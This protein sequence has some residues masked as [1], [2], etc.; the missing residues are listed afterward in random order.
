MLGERWSGKCKRWSETWE[1][2]NSKNILEWPQYIVNCSV[3]HRVE[4]MG[5][6]EGEKNKE[7]QDRSNLPMILFTTVHVLWLVVLSVYCLTSVSVQQRCDFQDLPDLSTKANVLS[8]VRALFHRA[9]VEVGPTFYCYWTILIT[10]CTCV[11]ICSSCNA[12]HQCYQLQRTRSI[13]RLN[14]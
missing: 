4:K 1:G 14:N 3:F 13:F 7:K 8:M 10:A 9:S 12:I 2:I 5:A 6:K 11:L